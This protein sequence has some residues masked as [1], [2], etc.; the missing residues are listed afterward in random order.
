VAAVPPSPSVAVTVTPDGTPGASSSAGVKDHDQE[1]FGCWTT[2]PTEAA[3]VTSSAP[4]SP[5]RPVL[6]IGDPSGPSTTAVSAVTVG[7]AFVTATVAVAVVV[8]P[9]PSVTVKVTT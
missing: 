9:S 4:A 8:P 5:K 1:P 7:F 2:T 3:S 6:V